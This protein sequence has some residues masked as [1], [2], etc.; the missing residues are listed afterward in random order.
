MADVNVV[1]LKF[2]ILKCLAAVRHQQKYNLLGRSNARG[3]LER[4]LEVTFEPE[5]R[6][7]ADIAFQELE[8]ADLIC[9]TYDDLISPGLWVAIT[10]AGRS[11]LDR[12]IL[13]SL[14]EALSRISPALVELRAGA[15]AAVTSG[16]PDSLRQAAHSARE[17]IDQMLKSGA[18]D[19]A[20]VAMQGFVADTSSRTG[21]TR[22]HRLRY[23]MNTYHGD[24]SDT[25]VKVV[26]EACDLVLA[27]D[28]QLKGMAHSRSV[29]ALA[30]VRDSLSAAEIAL[31]RLL[32]PRTAA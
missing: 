30:D 5:Q 15:W 3:N 6:R 18:P 19:E 7:L 8:N 25:Q 24:V 29:P 9:P 27:V 10:N 4:L 22:R 17:L 14:D 21:V 12:R 20:V 2:A 16:R 11:A 28:E 23:L 32:L 31:R 13:D 26:E 1:S